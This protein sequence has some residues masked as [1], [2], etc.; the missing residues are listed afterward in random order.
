MRIRRKPW[1]EKELAECGFYI[2]KPDVFKGKW[3]E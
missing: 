2:D 1:A 3:K